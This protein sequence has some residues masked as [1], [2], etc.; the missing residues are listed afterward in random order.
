MLFISNHYKF[1]AA[2]VRASISRHP[3][4]AK[5]QLLPGNTKVFPC[6]T[7]TTEGH[8]LVAQP[9]TGL[10]P[11]SDNDCKT[12]PIDETPTMRTKQIRVSSTPHF[13]STVVKLIAIHI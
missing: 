1:E 2:N 10:S 3:T 11:G 12:T 9:T 7:K 6:H 8:T 4:W 13:V 5:K